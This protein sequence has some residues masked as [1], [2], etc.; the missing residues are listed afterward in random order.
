MSKN[1]EFNRRSFFAVAAASLAAVQ[2]DG[3]GTAQAQVASGASS[4]VAAI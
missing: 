1:V 2:I 4:C 3:L